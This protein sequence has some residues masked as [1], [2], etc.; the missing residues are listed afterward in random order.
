M[1]F[2]KPNR[3]T[4]QKLQQLIVIALCWMFT[5]AVIAIFEHLV[6]HTQNSLG[7]V[8]R[9]SL[10]SSIALNMGIGFSGALLG[11]SFLVF[12]VN[13]RYN[14]KP[15]GYTLLIV[16]LSFLC[17]ILLVN[18]VLNAFSYGDKFR[19]YKNGLVWAVV[20][21]LTQLL[22]QVNSKFGQGIFWDII[23]GKYNTPKEEKR[24]FMFLDLNSSTTI[25]ESLGDKTYHQLLKDIFQ[26]ITNPILENKG[27]IYQYVGDEVVVAWRYLDGLKNNKCINCFFDIKSQLYTL[28]DKYHQKYHL[29]P[30]FKAGI[31]CGTVIAGEVGVIKRDITYSGDVLNTTSR[32]QQMCKEFNQEMVVSITLMEELELN[33]RYHSL[34]LGCIK[35][36][37]KDKEM[38]LVA[39]NQLQNL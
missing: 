3:R 18:E 1:S 24:I 21:S 17:V 27:E 12:F 35:L 4:N 30:T 26:D 32:I 38:Q 39:I 16:A 28:R 23:R 8:E 25:A 5:G 14:D 19:F 15:Y 33:D 20:V 2:L 7:P 6:L 22:L 11:G 13:V 10:L 31:H 9:Y 37:G 34:M 29:L 36:R